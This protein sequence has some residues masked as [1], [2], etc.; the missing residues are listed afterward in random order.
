M[1]GGSL[2]CYIS[3]QKKE[4]VISKIIL[5]SVTFGRRKEE[6]SNKNKES[7]KTKVENFH[8]FSVAM[9]EGT[10]RTQLSWNRQGVENNL[11]ISGLNASERG[12]YTWRITWRQE[13]VSK[14]GY[15]STETSCSG[16]RWKAALGSGGTVACLRLSPSTWRIQRNVTWNTK[17]TCAPS[18]SKWGLLLKL[19]Q[20]S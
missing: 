7:L 10:D 4:H 6:L 1:F 17:E 12:D 18:P 20:K 9:D 8:W 3:W 2:K 5:S 14:P 13:G 16:A 15:P 11:G 19:F